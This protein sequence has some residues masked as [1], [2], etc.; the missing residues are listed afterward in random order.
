MPQSQTSS[1]GLKT[2]LIYSSLKK[3]DLCKFDVGGLMAV[4][5]QLGGFEIRTQ[6]TCENNGTDIVRTNSDDDGKVPT[7]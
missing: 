1:D 7:E 3:K 4:L 2:L 6:G 5:F